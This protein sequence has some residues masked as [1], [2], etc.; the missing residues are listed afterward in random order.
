MNKKKSVSWGALAGIV[1]FLAFIILL[2]KHHCPDPQR[3]PCAAAHPAS[4][5]PSLKKGRRLLPGCGFDEPSE[6]LHRPVLSWARQAL[7]CWG[8][9]TYAILTVPVDQ[10]DTV[11]PICSAAPP[12][13]S[14]CRTPSACCSVLPVWGGAISMV[15][16]V[17]VAPDSGR[18]GG[19]RLCL[20]DRPAGAAAQERLP[21]HCHPWALR[22]SSAPS[23]SGSPWAPITNGANMLKSFPT[24][25][26]FNIE[27]A[28]GQTVPA[29]VHLCPH[30]DCSGLHLHHRPADQLLLRPGPSRPSVRT[31]SRPRPWASTWPSTRCSPSASPPSLPA[32]AA[33]C[34]PCMPRQ[35]PGQGLY[36]Y[37]EPMSCC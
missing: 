8:A 13:S 28:S 37:H 21:G 19:S 26:D 11:L 7:C 35:R 10:K 36:L 1:V 18:P 16:G 12:S 34:S 17:L 2:E 9:Y 25:S 4:C 27:N 6:R 23:S 5:S 29:P 33:A 20:P 24:F 3:T 14:P 15:L 22:K 30:A 32:W 31:K